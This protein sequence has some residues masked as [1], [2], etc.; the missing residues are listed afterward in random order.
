MTCIYPFQPGSGFESKHSCHHPPFTEGET[1]P[2]RAKKLLQYLH[3]HRLLRLDLKLPSD[4]MVLFS[5]MTLIRLLS[6]LTCPSS[7]LVT[8]EGPWS[9]SYGS[10]IPPYNINQHFPTCSL[11]TKQPHILRASSEQEAETQ[12]QIH[13]NLK[14]RPPSSWVEIRNLGK[15]FNCQ[16]SLALPPSPRFQLPRLP[17]NPESGAGGTHLPAR[18][19]LIPLRSSLPIGPG[20]RDRG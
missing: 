13:I 16:A 19:T 18:P 2:Q 5:A 14:S 7:S 15:V 6:F 17:W 11:P 10:F 9:T 8:G 3:I 4:S 20:S 12:R 1:D